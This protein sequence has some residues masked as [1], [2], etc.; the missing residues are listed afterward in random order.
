MIPN[1]LKLVKKQW[2]KAT[3][4]VD[5]SA[6]LAR[7][8]M[9]NALTQLA[10]N[11]IQGRRPKDSNGRYQKATA[12]RPPMNRSGKL[13]QSIRGERYRTGFASYSAIVGP[14]VIY[15]R[16]IELGG[17]YAPKSWHGTSAMRG[18]PYM[19]PAFRKF[20]GVVSGQI[21]NKYFGK[22]I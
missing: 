5:T 3:L 1:N 19:E 6:R 22:G 18:F 8:E 9:M 17:E 4:K 10:K 14:T 11:E 16:S 20:Q 21:I 15:G 12:G 7:D 2:D 13:R